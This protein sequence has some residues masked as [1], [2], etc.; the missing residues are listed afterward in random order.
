MRLQP[1]ISFCLCQF[2]IVEQVAVST[3][4]T[5]SV[6]LARIELRVAIA[7]SGTAARRYAWQ[8][9]TPAS[10]PGTRPPSS[11]KK[12]AA[13]SRVCSQDSLRRLRAVLRLS[14]SSPLRL[15]LAFLD[16]NTLRAQPLG[17]V[18]C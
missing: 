4:V 10:R 8:A 15:S 13:R 12:C 18:R 16:L 7:G 9:V 11:G 1:A 5:K 2:S 3:V 14:S 17:L 6:K